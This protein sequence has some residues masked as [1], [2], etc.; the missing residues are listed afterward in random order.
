MTLDTL[1]TSLK[2]LPDS[3]TMPAVFV[4]HGSP[5]NALEQN[6][7]TKGWGKLADSLP[8]P[9]AVL[10]ISA[11]WLTE[12]T[13]VHEGKMPRTIHDFWGFP[14]ELY[15]LT[16]PCPGSPEYA[17][18]V[19]MLMTESEVLSDLNWGL[20]HGAWVVLRHM[21]P[22]A[23]I[24]VFQMSIDVARNSEQHY[25]LAKALIPLRKKGVLIIGSGNLV[26]NLGNI[27]WEET[28][29]PFDWALEFDTKA[30]ELMEKGDHHSL[31]HHEKLGRSAELSIPTPD[32]YWP[33]IYTLALQE[34]DEPI[35]F[36]IQGISHGS[37]SMR[38]LRIGK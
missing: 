15:D 10:M 28:A 31:I 20:D 27:S 24:P 4:G 38:T 1:L 22:E 11:H 2:N 37:I 29:Q 8:L 34:K 32:H 17:S 33:L 35:A 3:P 16:Y 18:A 23:N 21:Y 12:G 9:K 6:P 30:T 5:M 25:A 26:H 14:K 19:K 36:P 13:F 7:Y